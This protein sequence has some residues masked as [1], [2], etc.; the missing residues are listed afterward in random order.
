[1]KNSAVCIL[2]V[3]IFLITSC[4]DQEPEDTID[5][6]ILSGGAYI[7]I[8]NRWTV[9]SPLNDTTLVGSNIDKKS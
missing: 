8:P 9:G 3:A 5:S 1:M 6:L 7:L 4:L 2:T